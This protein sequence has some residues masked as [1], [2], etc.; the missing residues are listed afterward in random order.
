MKLS[1]FINLEL[2]KKK[3]LEGAV[4]ED[5]GTHDCGSN[6]NH[7]DG[8]LELQEFGDAVVDVAAPQHCFHNAAEVVVSQDDVGRLFGH[9][10]ASNS[11]KN[12]YFEL[13]KSNFLK[14]IR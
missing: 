10:S 3:Y 13:E 5:A 9:V 8:Q 12:D 4:G 2:M 11:L 1:N 7:V 6:S 14:I